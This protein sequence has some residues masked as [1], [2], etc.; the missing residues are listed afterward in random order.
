MERLRT[1]DNLQTTPSTPKAL[2]CTI[3]FTRLEA[4]PTAVVHRLLVQLPQEVI[5]ASITIRDLH[6]RI[7]EREVSSIVAVRR[8]GHLDSLEHQGKTKTRQM[9][10][11]L[12][13]QGRDQD[14]KGNRMQMH[15]SRCH[16]LQVEIK[17]NKIKWQ[18]CHMEVPWIRDQL[19]HHKT[20]HCQQLTAANRKTASNR[21]RRGRDTRFQLHSQAKTPRTRTSSSSKCRLCCSEKTLQ[22]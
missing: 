7:E 17:I 22:H 12:E 21:P 2:A 9:L 18:T 19:P 3:P 8:L 5:T 6:Q 11:R 20:N 4:P 15:P 16:P 1:L 14:L 10:V 13:G